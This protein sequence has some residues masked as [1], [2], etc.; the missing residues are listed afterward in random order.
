[1]S[2][3]AVLTAGLGTGDTAGPRPAVGRAARR[4]PRTRR[5]WIGLVYVAPAFAFLV[6][7]VLF[8]LTRVVSFSFYDW[9]GAGEATWVGF[10]N[11]QRMLR[12]EQLHQA[13]WH[14]LVFIVT[15]SVLPICIGLL[16]AGLIGRRRRRGLAFFRIL[17]FVPQVTTLV[18]VGVAWRWVYAESGTLNQLLGL[19]GIPADT[20]WLGSFTWALPAV[21]LIGTWVM[22]GFCMLLFLAGMGKIDASLYDA[23]RID[24]AGAVREF[25]T[26]TAPALRQEVIVAAVVTMIGALRTFDLVYVTTLGGPGHSTVVPGFLVYRLAFR[27]GDVGGAATVAVLLI[28]MIFMIVLLITRTLRERP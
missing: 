18:A 19:V 11:Y 24:G 26:V 4:R 5:Q 10:G 17:L 14:S 2:R 28:L 20:A 15:Y 27:A 9:S 12:S 8:P 7:F 13:L 23:A 1:M 3:P 16:V 25:F 22:S 6:A 21:G